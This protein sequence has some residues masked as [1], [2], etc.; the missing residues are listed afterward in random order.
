MQRK[1]LLL[2]LALV[3]LG[4]TWEAFGQSQGFTVALRGAPLSEAL[5]RFVDATGEAVS[6]EPALVR[7][8]T[9]S[10]AM[11]D[12]AAEEVLRCILA[13]TGLDFHQLSSGTYVLTETA[14]IAPEYGF[15]AGRVVD[16]DTGSPLSGAHVMLAEADI[17][18]VTD[19]S[20]RFTFP[21][22]LP[23]SYVVSVQHIG[24]RSWRD[25]LVVR[26][27]E[28][29]VAE[30]R[31]RS[32]PILITP[33]I[34][35]A[36][37]DQQRFLSSELPQIRASEPAIGYA[38]A[39]DRSYRQVRAISGVRLNDVT[40][41]VHVQGG[42]PGAHQLRLDGV[43][44]FLPRSVAGLIG[45]FSSFG[46]EKIR[47]HKAGFGADV[48]S[49]LGGV[50]EAEHG[51]APVN[52]VEMQADPYSF[53]TRLRIAPRLPFASSASG[54]IAARV[55]LSD[56]HAPPRFSAMLEDWARPDQF[57]L[58]APLQ[59]DEYELGGTPPLLRRSIQPK[60]NYSDLH[61][62]GRLRFGPL[63]G[64]DA[65]YYQ[66]RQSIG[67]GIF[68]DHHGAGRFF[69]AAELAVVDS[70][71]WMNRTAQVRYDA[72][73]GSR[74]LA[75][76]Q[77]RYG[78]YR[79]LHAY[80]TLDS[81]R[82]V[83]EDST[84]HLTSVGTSPVRDANRV[85]TL[86]FEASLDHASDRHHVQLGL[87]TGLL[88]SAFHLRSV[89]LTTYA[90][91]DGHVGEGLGQDG[92]GGLQTNGAGV[93]NSS[94]AW[95][96]ALF[97][98]DRIA[99]GERTKLDLGLRLTYLHARQSV[100]AEPR[101]AVGYHGSS[102][103]LGRWSARSSAGLYRQFLNQTDASQLSA[104]V[105]LPS[106]RIWLPIDGS[107]RPPMAYH[108]AQEFTLRPAE[109]WSIRVD[110]YVK[111]Q[112]HGLALSYA[113]A[114]SD[115]GLSGRIRQEDFLVD[116]NAMSYGG[117]LSVGWRTSYLRTEASYSYEHATR[118][119]NALFDGRRHPLPWSEPH[120]LELGLDWMPT[121]RLAL[122]TR[123]KGVWGR[124]WGFRQAY[125]D[126]FGHDAETRHHP[127]VDLGDPAE[128]VLPPLYQLD[129]SAAY[130]QPIGA[131]ALQLR[132]EVVNVLGRENVMDWRLV[133]EG[134]A[135]RKEAR[136]LYPMLPSLAAR[137]TF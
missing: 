33:V 74:S 20:G 53:N 46:L 71:D 66:G 122:S 54:M 132:A 26:P 64:L 59:G 43:P 35:D 130:T 1:R 67:G 18:A 134:G 68:S 96:A 45:P 60:L 75:R 104:G 99:L 44:V 69:D 116:T 108:L 14:E 61:A 42:D 10:C 41:D 136:T 16:V 73:L 55:G 7:G 9:A 8:R 106:V 22:L 11:R 51:L 110:G 29:L 4:G 84:L 23:G 102:G 79:L 49:Q 15:L 94:D 114:V 19:Q 127:P 135:W 48:G 92:F 137:L 57:V 77:L 78:D 125:Y 63:R 97:G 50:L 24:Y 56:V 89:R 37:G 121:S 12:A 47:V 93:Y 27:Q 98:E 95:Y 88:E 113:P 21:A 17:G 28:Q 65:S 111:I 72:V 120:R 112:P 62:A 30:A 34:V 13:D 39:S 117:D 82:V 91:L 105:L 80:E 25:S 81:V 100:F 31:L 103:P 85:S 86:A 6:Y 131:A 124:S 101:A 5:Q 83:I 52:S 129:V 76:V 128:H 40:A 90:G 119:S 115:Q 107:V 109:P 70:Y 123:W 118:A 133:P 38:A 2:A 58:F 3:L 126:Y 36:Y 87:E 32:D